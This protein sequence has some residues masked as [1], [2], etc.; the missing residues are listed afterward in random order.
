MLS[1]ASMTVHVHAER[2]SL[3]WTA[4]TTNQNGTSLTDLAGHKLHYGLAPRSYS[5]TVDVGLATSVVLS[6]LEVG[7]TYY[8]A[9]TA[10]DTSGNQSAFSDEVEYRI[11]LT[12][13]DGDGLL[14]EEERT[15]YGTDPTRADTDG[16][17]LTDGDEVA[18]WGAAW[19]ADADG[20]GLIN[21]LDADSDNDTVPDGTEHSQGSD[22]ADPSSVPAAGH[23]RLAVNAGGAAFTA[24]DGTSYQA[25]TLFSG[26]STY[27]TTA[28]IAGTSDDTLYRDERYGNFTYNMPVANGDYVVTLKFA[29]VFF[30][31]PGLRVFDVL[32]EGVE[33]VSNLDVFAQVGKHT[34]YDVEVPVRVL[35]GTLTITFRSQVNNAKVNAILIEVP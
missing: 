22:P 28:A 31:A 10:Y 32:M 29:E 14:D 19:N 20:D 35:D 26:G 7:Q 15:V 9:A 3:S 5:V 11:P 1:V 34:A 33:V 27:K 13:T 12:D 24:A 2:V 21:L 16:D 30:S 4:P 23:V 6:N 25:D 17:G 18:F 8:F